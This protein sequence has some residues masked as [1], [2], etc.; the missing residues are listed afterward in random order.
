M[1]NVLPVA[2]FLLI[3]LQF[4]H[5]DS[6]ND[7]ELRLFGGGSPHEGQVEIC[8][9]QRWGSVNNDVWSTADTMVVCRQLGY[10][11]GRLCTQFNITHRYNH[12]R[13]HA[14]V[15]ITFKVKHLMDLHLL[16]KEPDQY[17]WAV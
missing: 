3:N 10:T 1:P 2:F 8:L 9:N 17:C 14:Y 16:A 12:F 4:L 6:C 15:H 7:G 11:E 13:Q 5:K